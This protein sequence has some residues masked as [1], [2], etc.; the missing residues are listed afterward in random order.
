MMSAD[1]TPDSLAKSF[2]IITITSVLVYAGLVLT[3][4]LASDKAD[5]DQPQPSATVAVVAAAN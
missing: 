2:F 1:T 5:T 4:M 3:L